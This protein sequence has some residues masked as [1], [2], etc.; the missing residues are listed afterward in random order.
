MFLEVISPAGKASTVPLE[1]D[2]L[3]VGTGNACRVRLSDPSVARCHARIS[4]HVETGKYFIL[5]LGS[6]WGTAVNGES[7]VRYGPLGE[8][9]VI[10]IGAHKLKV[11]ADATRA[12]PAIP[13]LQPHAPSRGEPRQRRRRQVHR[14]RGRRS[15]D[16]RARGAGGTDPPGAV[17]RARPATQRRQPHERPGTARADAAADRRDARPRRLPRAH[18]PREARQPTCS[19][20]PWASARSNRCSPTTPSPRSWS[21][22]AATYSSSAAAACSA[23]RSPS[24]ATRRCSA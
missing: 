15:A 23:R 20:K 18:R 7:I 11:V 14:R 22:A 3:D 17:R 5:D 2:S 19:T 13:T 10:A 6:A 8:A 1:A 21:T 24:A 9:D 12:A 4:R 16:R